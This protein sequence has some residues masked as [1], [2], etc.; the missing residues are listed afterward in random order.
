[1]NWIKSKL[2]L[3]KIIWYSWWFNLHYLPFKQAIRLP[4]YL[5]KPKLLK[6]K[7][8][9]ILDGPIYSG[10]IKLGFKR[11]SIFRESGVAWENHGGTVVFKGGASIGSGSAI[12]IGD[13][14]LVELG[15][16]FNSTYGLKLVSYYSVKVGEHGSL[17]WNTL[18]MDTNFHKLYDKETNAP[19]PLG[20]KIEIGEYNWFG[21]DC[22]IMHSVKTPERCIFG[23]GTIVTR[24]T[25]MEPYAITGGQPPRILHR[26]V[27]RDFT[28]G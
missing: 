12:S 26:N 9:I 28:E 19:F 8:K 24:S 16:D 4:I 11:V 27:Y 10:K 6:C 22:K 3:I 23:M 14:S 2:K 13:R 20:G 17:G 18:I 21:A 7:G 5:W 1:M 15:D 25:P